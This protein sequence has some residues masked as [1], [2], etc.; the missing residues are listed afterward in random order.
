MRQG[1]EL[2]R[3][4]ARHL[5]GPS[6]RARFSRYTAGSVVAFATSEVTLIVCFGSGLMSAAWASV[7]AFFAGAIP[8]YVLNRSWVWGRRGRP[9]V[10]RELVPYVLVSVATLVIAAFATSVAAD[11]APG[12]HGTQTLFVAVA[13]LVTYG[14]LFVA[15]FVIYQRVIF[16]DDAL[17]AED[18]APAVKIPGR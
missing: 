7:V 6:L 13:Y 8:N 2:M 12:G 5:D 3:G 14:V 15:K 18:R 10:R 16:G 4:I 11:V 17:L 9:H 1:S